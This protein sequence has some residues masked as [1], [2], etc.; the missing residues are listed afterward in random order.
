MKSLILLLIAMS[1]AGT[2]PFIICIALSTI[3]DNHISARFRYRCLKYCLLLYLVPFPLLEYFIYHRYFSTPKPLN[4]DVVISLTEKIVQTFYWI[5]F[6][7]HRTFTGNIY[8]IMD[9]FL[10][11]NNFL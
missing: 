11:Y 2:L 7:F 6:K 1:A 4:G 9:L 10:K 5:L 3:F 8:R